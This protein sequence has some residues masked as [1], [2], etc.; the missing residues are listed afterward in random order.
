MKSNDLLVKKEEVIQKPYPKTPAPLIEADSKKT[1]E[2][3]GGILL[4]F[5]ESPTVKKVD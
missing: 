1:V 2:N 3:K 5:F 4:E